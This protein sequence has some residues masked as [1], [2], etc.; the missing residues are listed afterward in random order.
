MSDENNSIADQKILP[1]GQ[2]SSSGEDWRS[3]RRPTKTVALAAFLVVGAVAGAGAMRI[4]DR[5]Q[6]QAV[7]LLQPTAI[8]LLRN[9]TP[10][11]IKGKVSSVFGNAFVVEDGTG[12]ALVDTGPRGEGRTNVAPDE[13]VTV[14]GRFDR[15]R[16]QAQ[17]LIRADGTGVGFGPPK[18]PHDPRAP[19]GAPPFA[20]GAPTPDRSPPQ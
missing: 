13:N 11:A 14:Q 18:P 2:G 19:G 15:G 9:D 16:L 12:R 1:S 17:M 7:M 4:A 5:M 8:N 20:P 3:W 10:V 6:P